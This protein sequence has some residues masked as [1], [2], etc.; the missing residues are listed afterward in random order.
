MRTEDLILISNIDHHEMHGTI[1]RPDNVKSIV[2]LLHGLLDHGER[3]KDLA[4]ELA[5]KDHLVL[6]PDL[7]GHGN[8]PVGGVMGYF[9]KTDGYFK[10]VRDLYQLVNVIRKTYPV[11]VV[12]IGVNFGG[13]F[14]LEYL[15]RY[16]KH[17]K[18][19]FL[20]GVPS[21]TTL[22]QTALVGLKPMLNFYTRGKE[23]KANAK[24][25]KQIFKQLSKEVDE[26]G[27]S[28]AWLSSDKENQLNYQKD[29]LCGFPLTHSGYLE[30]IK[31]LEDVY[32][33]DKW[34]IH[35]KALFIC[36]FNGIYDPLGNP[37][38]EGVNKTID[39]ITKKGYKNTNQSIYSKSRHEIFFDVQKEEVIE[40]LM[41]FLSKV[42]LDENI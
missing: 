27:S 33:K 12:L 11:G 15:K 30:M 5:T 10:M 1:Y 37:K 21:V 18:A 25:R 19:V 6:V 9:G 23:K 42:K 7:R 26:S 36:I 17:L 28:Y 38:G 41:F 32:N 39:F 40:D 14:A 13:L 34:T 8:S 2:L 24:W 16:S 31:L 22:S 20:S 35:N 4:T 3:Y 29:P